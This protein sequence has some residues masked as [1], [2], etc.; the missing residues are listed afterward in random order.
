MGNSNWRHIQQAIQLGDWPI[1]INLKEAYIHVPVAKEF[2]EILPVS[3]QAR[4]SAIHLPSLWANDF[5]SS[6]FQSSFGHSDPHQAERST[7]LSLPRRPLGAVSGQ[8]STAGLQGTGDL[9][10]VQLRVAPKHRKSHLYPGQHRI[11]L[12]GLSSIQW[13]TPSLSRLKK[14]IKKYI[15]YS[16][17]NLSGLILTHHV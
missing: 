9:H 6:L 8:I 16:R 12:G 4:T 11:Y 14:K 17:D 10:L 7:P 13:R 2:S 15:S 3:S 5:S 1:S